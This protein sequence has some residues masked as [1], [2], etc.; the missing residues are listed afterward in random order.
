MILITGV[1]AMLN[2]SHG[3][4]SA[5]IRPVVYVSIKLRLTPAVSCQFEI[6]DLIRVLIELCCELDGFYG[7]NVF[8]Y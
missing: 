2:S 3:K 6:W 7:T 4:L 8:N 5:C 1:N